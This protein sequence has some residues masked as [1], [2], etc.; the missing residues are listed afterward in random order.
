MARILVAFYN[1]M[2]DPNNPNAKPIFYEAFINGL[3]QAGNE[4]AVMSH[5]LFG[6]NFSDIDENTAHAIKEWNPDI[7]FIFNNNFGSI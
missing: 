2:N 7:C 5:N 6:M 3:D 4:V 1:C